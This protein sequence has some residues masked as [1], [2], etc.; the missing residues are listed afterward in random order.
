MADRK[1][2]RGFGSAERPVTKELWAQDSRFSPRLMRDGGNHDPD[3]R[4]VDYRR[5]YDPEFAKAEFDRLWPKTWIFACREEDIPNVGDRVPFAIGSLSFFIVRAGPQQFGAFYNSC[6]HR[7]TKLCSALESADSIRCSYHAWEWNLDGS[8][9][10][11]PSHWDFRTTNRKNGGLREV[12]FDRWAGFIFINLD[13]DAAPL[14]EALSV[15][16]DHFRDYDLENRY[17]AGRIRKLVPANWK[18]CLEAFQESYHVI[19]THP[20]A[21]PYNGDSQAQYDVWAGAN[22]HVGRQITPSAVPSMHAGS[23]ADALTAAY[24]YAE[25]ARDWHYPDADLPAIDP[26]RNVRTQIADWHRSVQI[27]YFDNVLDL[28]DAVM[29]DSILYFMFPN[30]T[31]WLSES[32]PFTYLFL[33][34]AEDPSMSYME[35]RL[36]RRYKQ[37]EPRPPSAPVIEIGPDE[38]VVEKAAVFGALGAIFDQDMENLVKVQQGLRAAD[39]N[40]HHSIL[41]EYQEAIIQHWHVL[42]D[43]HVYNQK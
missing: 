40:E 35:V 27:K 22:G 24:V 25:V 34:H 14:A 39:P 17:T 38:S 19:G 10:H 9:Q 4:H 23:D 18:T 15:I 33:P 43:D 30:F 26:A 31:I 20:Q 41:G 29:V 5:Y 42:L 3:Y 2:Q 13:D 32:L 16:P 11:I 8:L 28:P 36:L 37:G 12:R 6:R 7:G 1:I 21:V